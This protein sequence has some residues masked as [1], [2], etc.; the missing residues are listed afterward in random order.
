MGG[1]GTLIGTPPNI[2]FAAVVRRM[3]IGVKDVPFL[4]WMGVGVPLAAIMLV[5]IYL[6]LS[7]V[8]YRFDDKVF[9]TDTQHLRD[10]LMALGPMSRGEVY[11]AIAF[12]GTALLWITRQDIE[13]GA[14]TLPGWSHLLPFGANIHDGTVAIAV[15]I[16]LFILPVDRK[17]GIF[18]MDREWFH[19]IP[20]DIVML[21]GGGFALAQGFQNSGLSTFLGEQLQFL[22]D[23]PVLPMMILITLFMTLITNLTSNTA[24][25]TVMLPILASTALAT[26]SPPMLLMLPATFAASAAFMLPVGTPPNAII[27]GSGRITIPQM[28][29]A[30][31]LITLISA[32]IIALVSW[33]L[34][35]IMLG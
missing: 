4:N 3:D 26:Q 28:M 1:M 21:F 32:P 19:S 6:V 13:L 17:K 18:L 14:F 25:T 8:L 31:F 16:L 29:R 35:P 20:W 5:V 34:G 12:T 22:G 11:I 27:F 9:Q 23:L 10:E 33:W 24:T 7:R 15:S 30:G 2:V